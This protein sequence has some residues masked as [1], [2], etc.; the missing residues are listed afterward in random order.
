MGQNFP[1]HGPIFPASCP[2]RSFRPHSFLR[3]I[4]LFPRLR[5]GGLRP[6][7]VASRL[8]RAACGGGQLAG[9][10]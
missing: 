8:M 2:P 6:L 5:T 7:N 1:D 9:L 3:T 4:G 10:L